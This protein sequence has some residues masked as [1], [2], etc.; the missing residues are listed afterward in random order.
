MTSLVMMV[1][2]AFGIITGWWAKNLTSK[3]N[4]K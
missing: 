2:F 4:K 3:M 1:A